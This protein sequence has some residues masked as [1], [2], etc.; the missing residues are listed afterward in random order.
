MSPATDKNTALKQ[1]RMRI[2]DAAVACFLEN[3]Y[4]QTGI[5]EIAKK[6]GIS[7]GNLYNHFPSKEAVLAEIAVLDREELQ[8]FLAIL[9]DHDKPADTL[10][11][12]ISAYSAYAAKPESVVLTVEIVSEAVH[13]PEIA[14]L[15]VDNWAATIDAL[16]ALLRKGASD[17]CF[18]DFEDPDDIAELILDS[19]E[20]FGLRQYLSASRKP[21]A[22][23]NLKD[24]IH[25]AT[26]P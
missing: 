2:I 12:F 11:R 6:A 18:R 8:P 1:R 3:G 15:F 7:L 25:H 16:S 23:A 22:F 14:E 26:R 20:S 17:G 21:R 19:I 24:Y 9:D 13:K 10:M 5:R 4:H